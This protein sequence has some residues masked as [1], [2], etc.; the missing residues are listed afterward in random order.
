MANDVHS[1]ACEQVWGSDMVSLNRNGQYWQA[2]WTDPLTGRLCRR[3]L[4]HKSTLSR[5]QALAMC[6]LIGDE[7]SQAATIGMTHGDKLLTLGEWRDQWMAMRTDLLPSSR[8]VH[9]RHWNSILEQ[10]GADT[11]MVA[12]TKSMAMETRARLEAAADA[13]C[14]VGTIA[15]A[16]A[17]STIARTCRNARLYWRDAIKFDLL[18]ENPWVA[19]R[20]TAPEVQIPRRVL[21]DDEIER[22]LA[23]C[24]KP[25]VRLL[26]SLCYYGG[27]RKHE[28]LALRWEH[29]DFIRHRLSVYPP[30]GRTSSKHRFRDVRLDRR[31]A[32]ILTEALRVGERICQQV[33]GDRA[34]ID[35]Q[36]A[37]QSA[38]VKGDVSFQLMRSSRENHWMAD[39]PPNVVTAWLGHSAQVAARHYRGVPEKFYADDPRDAEIRKLKAQLEMLQAQALQKHGRNSEDV[40]L[41]R[42]KTGV[43]TSESV[44]GDPNR[45]VPGNPRRGADPGVM[46]A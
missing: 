2:R 40:S 33:T 24:R 10:I 36:E 18:R 37:V 3:S 35:L 4:G 20:T 43:T 32:V 5:S 30:G 39:F 1:G 26:I 27:L 45:E 34:W 38:G 31:L 13:R 28:A 8:T 25:G 6:K 41:A 19:V 21:S 7:V 22:I 23:S 11:P 15:R 9:A 44:R 16:K 46:F 42:P 12:V 29:V 14:G 17:E